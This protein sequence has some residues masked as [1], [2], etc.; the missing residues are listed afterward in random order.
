MRGG[1][2]KACAVTGGEKTLERMKPERGSAVAR[3]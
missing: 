1:R 2:V 3:L